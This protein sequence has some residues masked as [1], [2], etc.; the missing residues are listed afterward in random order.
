MTGKKNGANKGE[1]RVWIKKSLVDT[2]P[3]S[4]SPTTPKRRGVRTITSPGLKARLAPQRCKSDDGLSSMSFGTNTTSATSDDDSSVASVPTSLSSNALN[5][6]ASLSSPSSTPVDYEWKEGWMTQTEGSQTLTIR[7]P[8]TTPGSFKDVVVTLPASKLSDEQS[9]LT[10]NERQ[11]QAPDDLVTLECF[12]EPTVV[13]CLSNRYARGQLYTSTGPVLLAVNPFRHLPNLYGDEI[14]E[15]YWDRVEQAEEASSSDPLPPHVYA[16]A[17]SSFRSMM[18]GIELGLGRK[19]NVKFDQSILVSGESGAGKTVTTKYLMKYLAALS[20]RTARFAAGGSRAYLKVR[21]KKDD[22]TKKRQLPSRVTATPGTFTG[23]PV[24]ATTTPATPTLTKRNSDLSNAANLNSSSTSGIE[25]RVLQSN[26]ILESFGNART[27]RNDNSSRFG[28]FIEMQFTKTGR[29]VGTK[30]ETYLLEKVRLVTQSAGERNYHVFYE[31]LSG[32]LTPEELEVFHLST[33]SKPTDFKILSS[34][35][36]DRRDGVSD[37][38]TFRSLRKAMNIMKIK[39]EERDDIFSVTAAILHASNLVFIEKAGGEEASLDT[40]N[41]HLEPAC[42]LLGVSADGLNEALCFTTITA[43]GKSI[44]K[45][46]TLQQAEKGLAA[47][48]KA[49]YGALFTFLV[50]RVNECITYKP[51]PEENEKMTPVATIG[52]LDIFGFESFTTNSFEQL[53]INYCNEALQQQFNTFMLKNEQAEYANEGIDW[54]FIKFPENQDVLDLIDHR[55]SGIMSLLDDLCRAPGANDKTFAQEL[56]K[57]CEGTPRFQA[58]DKA[59]ITPKFSINHYAGPVEYSTIGFVEKNRDDLP[60]ETSDLLMTSKNPFVHKLAEIISAT[61]STPNPSGKESS[62]TR[63]KPTVG[64]HF[65]HQV[66]DLRAKIDATSP[67]YVRCIKPNDLLVP[68]KYDAA[69]VAH[70]LRCGG[71]L[72]AVSITRA[73]FTLHYTHSDFIKRYGLLA[74]DKKKIFAGASKSD[75]ENCKQLIEKLLPLVEENSGHKESKEKKA[76]NGKTESNA[77]AAE[78]PIQFGKSKVLL[79]HHAFEVLEQKL[80]V[81]QNRCATRLNTEFRRYLCRVAFV[82]VR[83]TFRAE[84]ESR[85]ETFEHWFKENREIYYRKRDKKAI[86]IPN[87]VS[88]RMAMYQRNASSSFQK[89]ESSVSNS[90]K[91]VL[92]IENPAWI[93]KDDGAWHRNPNYKDEPADK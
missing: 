73:G 45:K 72:Q 75:K 6:K 7:V 86:A 20:Q 35:T 25:A 51:G 10:A 12:N 2:A 18:R 81:I 65:R 32:E 8:P 15:Q 88:Q 84:L 77:E 28:K 43:M 56:F 27:V 83:A 47:L 49:T 24:S 22:A 64:G 5:A 36:Y 91:K 16:V 66:K 61:Q 69:M 80:G 55:T 74:P 39:A 37:R 58:G 92:S 38:D 63:A 48:L 67:H 1:I 82:S 19:L 78:T 76:S 29:L 71:I 93:V 3:G 23:I 70:Q 87:I 31:L 53:C 11:E 50:D 26:P 17:D 54:D 52:V 68:G 79:K 60:R 14:M 21:R 4:P 42:H 34:G 44:R 62:K 46:H 33:R 13:E 57:M 9:L 41:K 30:I 90:D 85:G 59:S 89:S 40:Q